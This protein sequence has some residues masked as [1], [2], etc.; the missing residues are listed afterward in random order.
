MLC[1]L[2]LLSVV[3]MRVEVVK[4]TQGCAFAGRRFATD[5]GQGRRFTR[6]IQRILELCSWYMMRIRGC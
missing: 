5:Q 3:F 2:E 1:F 6:S 4:I